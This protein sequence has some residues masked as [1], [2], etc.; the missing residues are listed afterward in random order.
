MNILEPLAQALDVN[1]IELVQAKAITEET[2]SIQ[3]AE[4][5][6]SDTIQL[7]IKDEISRTIGVVSLG[8]FSS[9]ILFLL[10][11]L[12]TQGSI[13]VYSVG[14]IVTGLIAWAAPVWQMTLARARRTAVPGMVSLGAALTSVTIQFFQLAQEVDTGDFAAI[15]DTI[16]ALCMVVVLFGVAT[17]FLNLLMVWRS[18]NKK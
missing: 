9:V 14:S 16:H 1:L 7:S 2:I 5:I 18:K 12:L 11:F 4:M 15:E 17:L 10:W 3:E 8:L 6:V 13:V